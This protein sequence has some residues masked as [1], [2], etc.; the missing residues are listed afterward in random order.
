MEN[1]VNEEILFDYDEN[2]AIDDDEVD[3]NLSGESGRRERLRNIPDNNLCIL[4]SKKRK[5]IHFCFKQIIFL[6]FFPTLIYNI[7]WIIKIKKITHQNLVNF[8]LNKFSDYILTACYIV[9]AK[10][11]LILF[12]PQIRCGREKKINDFSYICVFIKALT[13]FF[14]SLY[15]TYKLNNLFVLNKDINSYDEIYYWINL[16]YKL[17]CFYLK[18]IY[19]IVG[20]VLCSILIVVIKEIFKAIRYVL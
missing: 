18:G 4:L 19:S 16:Y 12:F 1:E 2:A 15:F 14:C 8:D 11:I 7:F 6:S 9:L 10:G 3:S 17:E 20:I 13:T 5:C